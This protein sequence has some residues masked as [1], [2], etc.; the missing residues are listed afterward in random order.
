MKGFMR[1]TTLAKLNPADLDA[2]YRRLLQPKPPSR[3]SI[4]D[5][6][7]GPLF[8]QQPRRSA[9]DH[10]DAAGDRVDL[11]QASVADRQCTRCTDHRR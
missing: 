2:F 4:G 7:P 11:D 8:G 9:L 3:S 1:I 6:V 10:G 5:E